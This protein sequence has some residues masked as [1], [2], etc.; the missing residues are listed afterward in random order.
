MSSSSD[1]GVYGGNTPNKP[2]HFV[3]ANTKSPSKESMSKKAVKSFMSKKN[4]G[5]DPVMALPLRRD[6]PS[7]SV[8][9]RQSKV[10]RE[11]AAALAKLQTSVKP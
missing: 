11:L 7:R 4:S 9:R 8:A 6:S 10:E 5:G 3:T 2:P 1:R